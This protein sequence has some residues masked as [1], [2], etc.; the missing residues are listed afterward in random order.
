MLS[1]PRRH[2]ATRV[3]IGQGKLRRLVVKGENTSCL[4]QLA[5]SSTIQ[6]IE[7]LSL[8]G[9]YH[10]ARTMRRS[11]AS[12]QRCCKAQPARSERP[13]KENQ[14][15][16][17]KPSA[18]FSRQGGNESSQRNRSCVPEQHARRRL[19]GESGGEQVALDLSR[20][21]PRNECLKADRGAPRNKVPE[22]TS[23]VRKNYP[24]RCK[25]A[26]SEWKFGNLNL[27]R[28]GEW[29]SQF[30]L[31]VTELHNLQLQ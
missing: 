2:E 3:P 29:T 19:E 5:G 22:C 15:S 24:R 12:Y 20:K 14:I 11:A 31:R 13:V 18:K 21:E 1:L 6:D 28:V 9:M 17:Y 27:P 4:R 23:V 8:C 10:A 7:E 25:T 30:T 26:K 16:A